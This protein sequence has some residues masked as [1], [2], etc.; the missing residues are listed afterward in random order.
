MFS[1]LDWI[2]LYKK[3]IALMAISFFYFLQKIVRSYNIDCSVCKNMTDLM[4]F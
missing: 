2:P 1:R 4:R 3:D